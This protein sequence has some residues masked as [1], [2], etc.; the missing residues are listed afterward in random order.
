MEAIAKSRTIKAYLR[1][2]LDEVDSFISAACNSNLNTNSSPCCFP[3]AL[4][5]N[6]A[7]GEVA[8]NSLVAG[9]L[10]QPDDSEVTP[11]LS[12]H[13]VVAMPKLTE[14]ECQSPLGSTFGYLTGLFFVLRQQLL[15]Q[16][17]QNNTPSNTQSDANTNATTAEISAA[18][19][20]TTLLQ[21]ISATAAPVLHQPLT[22]PPHPQDNNNPALPR[23]THVKAASLD[24]SHKMRM[25]MLEQ[26]AVQSKM[27]EL[28]QKE[29]YKYTHS[30]P[31]PRQVIVHHEEDLQLQQ[32]HHQQQPPYAYSAAQYPQAFALEPVVQ[33]HESS[34]SHNGFTPPASSQTYYVLAHPPHSSSH[35]HLHPPLH[36]HHHVALYP[37]M[38][39]PNNPHHQQ[40]QQHAPAAPPPQPYQYKPIY[41]VPQQQPPPPQQQ[42]YQPP[43]TASSDTSIPAQ[44]QSRPP[45]SPSRPRALSEAV[46]AED[47][48]WIGGDMV[49]DHQL[50]EFLMNDTAH[51]EELVQ[52]T[53]DA[54]QQPHMN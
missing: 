41:P 8:G 24:E 31:P 10:L 39:D 5:Q 25:E 33:H 42:Q 34:F 22:E 43:H 23:H 7:S 26:M 11:P 47:F 52:P 51:D 27:R 29:I 9:L 38:H 6:L 30:D 48:F 35:S 28:K 32:Q 21:P 46:L 50:F 14:E 53:P 4:L 54:H 19:A 37:I 13:H 12:A 44:A 49:D 2:C 45:Q 15:Q 40:Q 16:R 36:N 20:T 3:L 18:G 1:F 17:M